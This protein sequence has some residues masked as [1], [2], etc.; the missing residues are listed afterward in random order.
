MKRTLEDI[1][2]DIFNSQW[3]SSYVTVGSYARIAS[4]M[5]NGTFF[6]RAKQEGQTLVYGGFKDIALELHDYLIKAKISESCLESYCQSQVLIFLNL[7]LKKENMDEKYSIF[8][9][10]FSKLYREGLIGFNLIMQFNGVSGDT[11]EKIHQVG[12]HF[13]IEFINKEKARLFCAPSFQVKFHYSFENA[14]LDSFFKKHFVS[15]IA[16]YKDAN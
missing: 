5:A 9:N 15:A 3:E 4:A 6:K 14:L 11:I 1:I 10:N 7:C 2:I 8:Y 13:V 12:K 16:L